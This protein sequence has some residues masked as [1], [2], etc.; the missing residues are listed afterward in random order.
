MFG[1]TL[2]SMET[3][4]APLV[5]FTPLIFPLHSSDASERQGRGI[6]KHNPE[7]GLLLSKNV[8]VSRPC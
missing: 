7:K 5:L 6:G 4:G 8:S 2:V 1:S 3:N